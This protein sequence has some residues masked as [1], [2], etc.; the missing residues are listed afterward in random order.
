MRNTR[1]PDDLPQR[2]EATLDAGEKA[3]W[4]GQPIPRYLSRAVAKKVAVSGILLVFAAFWLAQT[5]LGSEA[6]APGTTAFIGALAFGIVVVAI[7]VYL[8]LSPRR[9]YRKWQRRA[10]VVTDRRMLVFDGD[11]P[12]TLRCFATEPI[13]Q[14]VRVEHRDGTGDLLIAPGVSTDEDAGFPDEPLG[15]LRIPGADFVESMLS[16]VNTPE[17]ALPTIDHP[18][19]DRPFT[20]AHYTAL[21]LVLLVTLPL[22][23]TGHVSAAACVFFALVIA[24]IACAAVC[25]R[26]CMCP[27]CGTHLPRDS[28]APRGTSYFTCAHCRVRWASRVRWL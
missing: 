22:V 13:G 2:I 17:T 5:T 9:E 27:C 1:A 24:T 3:L 4:A 15:F 18:T 12:L 19:H 14:V 20:I 23:L 11:K 10:Y 8:A 21:A 25:S 26:S 7:G 28:D 16:Q 6:A